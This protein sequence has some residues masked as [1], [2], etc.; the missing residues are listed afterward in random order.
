M[1]SSKRWSKAIDAVLVSVEA[2]LVS[3]E[4]CKAGKCGW[5]D[6]MY[7]AQGTWRQTDSHLTWESMEW[8]EKTEL[9]T[10]RMHVSFDV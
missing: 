7:Q 6:L 4:Q 3:C 2:I 8:I 1:L 10:L 5:M 9:S